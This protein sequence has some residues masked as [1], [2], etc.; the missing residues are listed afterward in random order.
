MSD[1]EKCACAEGHLSW[2]G[3]P[4]TYTDPEGVVRCRKCQ[5]PKPLDKH[6]EAQ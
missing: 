6:S 2:D 5:K 4:A 1:E 3:L